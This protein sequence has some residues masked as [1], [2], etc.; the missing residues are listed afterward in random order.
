NNFLI[1]NN[2]VAGS[3]H[4]FQIDY[5]LTDTRRAPESAAATISTWGEDNNFDG[6]PDDWQAKYFGTDPSQWPSAN[7]VVNGA[8]VL[9]YFLWG[10][11]PTDPSTTLSINLLKSGNL[12]WNTQA[13]SIYQVQMTTD[14]K[15]WTNVGQ[16]RFAAGTT[17]SIP[18][19]PGGSQAF[20]HILLVH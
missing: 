2:L 11:D 14:F 7:T 12:Q 16:A 5:L 6:L 19:A 8:T 15:T 10:G 18:L 4:T 1:V 17:D 20:Y 3:T 13:G 9:Q